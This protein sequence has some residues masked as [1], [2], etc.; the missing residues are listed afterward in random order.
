MDKNVAKLRRESE[1]LQNTMA[2]DRHTVDG[3]EKLLAE[4]RQENVDQ[5]LINQELQAE[6]QRLK[7]KI[8]EL[9]SK[10][11]VFFKLI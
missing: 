11:Y 8:Q 6:I 10:L 2:H 7:H 1:T 4:C 5:T 3:L 9:H